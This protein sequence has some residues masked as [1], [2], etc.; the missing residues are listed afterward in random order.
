M[1]HVI[2]IDLGTTFSATAHVGSSGK[3]VIVPN[4][5]GERITPSVV[6]FSGERV[7]I[8]SEAKDRL[9]TGDCIGVQFFKRQMGNPDFAFRAG[10]RTYTAVDLSALLL[11]R[12]KRDAEAQLGG[13]VTGAVI[14]VPAYFRDPERRATIAAGERAGLRVLQTVNEPT[15]AA[16]AYGQAGAAERT[17]LLVYDLGGG[18]FDVTLLEL[19]R[20]G[21]AVVGSDGDHELGG[22]DWD[23]RI[24]GWVLEQLRRDHGLEPDD[25]PELE[26]LLRASCEEAKHRLSKAATTVIALRHRG[27]DL[28]YE[29]ARAT[30]E[31]LSADL[32]ARTLELSRSALRQVGWPAT[33]LRGILPVGGAT[34]MPMVHALLR[35]E[36]G[37]PILQ[38]V[39]V[40][41]AVALGAAVVGHD[42]RAAASG[43]L[44][45]VADVT[46]HSLGMIAVDATGTAYV[47]SVILPKN[48]TLPCAE[49]RPYQL[50]TRAGAGAALEVFV[51]QGE[52]ESPADVAYLGRYVVAEVPHVAAGPAVLDITY[53][54]DVSGVVQVVCRLRQTGVDLPVVVEA[55][56]ADIPERFLLPPPQD[57]ARAHVTAY[58][59]FDVSGSMAGEPLRKAQ[60]AALGFLR[61]VDLAHASIGV[62]AFSDRVA[63]KLEAAQNAGRIDAAIEGM[64][65]G[66][67]GY[68][69][70][71]DPFRELQS[72]LGETNGKC[73]AIVL[74]DGVWSN[75]RLAT[76]RAKACHAAG[77][78]VVA[79]GFGGADQDFLRAI[80]SSDEAGFF[81]SLGGL[82]AAFSTIAQVITEGGAAADVGRKLR[83]M[84][85]AD[86]R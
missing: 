27:R 39:D 25:D 45:R 13:A 66:E 40:D 55:L 5:L 76:E 79:V 60:D 35:A 85:R 3:P 11:A 16:V 10:D 81:T 2:G 42:A 77:I 52:S 83:L 33:D 62:I 67:T 70:Q 64:E 74:A 9:A 54:Y 36:F 26:P 68:G 84:G 71:T 21:I 12:L 38:G 28:R 59:A 34:R 8:G 4:A 41:A 43:R 14:T 46:S 51:T 1:G 73:F 47:N 37:A 44:V 29:F 6:G 32:L 53:R 78:D 50:N 15:A 82:Q 86:G 56:P 61:N 17:R 48:R 69:N 19:D 63:V 31:Q 57:T 72:L 80:A 65:C 23:E 18:T 30:F 49:T 22:K 20:E 75:Q 58:L 7:V 24:M